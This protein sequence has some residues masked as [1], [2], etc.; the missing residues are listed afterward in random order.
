MQPTLFFGQIFGLDPLLL[1]SIILAGAIGFMAWYF[2]LWTYFSRSQKK[3]ITEVEI[4]A[5]LV[6]IR[7][8]ARQQ[9]FREAAMLM[10]QTFLIATE[11]FLFIGRPPTQSAR[12]FCMGLI[13]RG[14]VDPASIMAIA[15]VFEKARYGQSPLTIQEFNDGLSGL[16]RYLQVVTSIGSEAEPSAEEAA[17]TA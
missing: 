2:K 13:S 11:G 9:Q 6:Q 7:Q 17:A 14:D 1:V 3:T 15:T 10:F 16:H 5:R 12:Q 8:L 4:E